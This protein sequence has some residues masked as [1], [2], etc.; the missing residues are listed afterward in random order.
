MAA[1]SAARGLDEGPQPGP[2]RRGGRV[3]LLEQGA[4]VPDSRRQRLGGLADAGGQRTLALGRILGCR[5]ER[6]GH[7][8]HHDRLNDF[9]ALVEP[10]IAGKPLPQGIAGVA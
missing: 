1:V 6:A 2:Q 10:F 3:D 7:W 5:F 4:C 8:V 9:M